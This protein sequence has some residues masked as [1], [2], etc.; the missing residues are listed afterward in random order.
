ML[1]ATCTDITNVVNYVLDI[2]ANDT[3]NGAYG[4]V[5]FDPVN[6]GTS[7]AHYMWCA[8]KR[9]IRRC[10]GTIFAGLSPEDGAC[11]N[12]E[13]PFSFTVP[14]NVTPADVGRCYKRKIP[15]LDIS[16]GVMITSYSSGAI[17][18]GV[19]I[20]AAAGVMLGSFLLM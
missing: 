18:T 20:L 17:A 9:T 2:L 6:Q 7:F 5:M 10:A 13:T 4:S 14:L 19:S 12:T 8:P 15:L 11:P 3:Y 16:F 1:A